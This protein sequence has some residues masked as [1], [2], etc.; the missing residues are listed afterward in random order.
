MPLTVFIADD[1]GIIRDGIS[2]LLNNESDIEVIGVAEH[3]RLAVE[4]ILKLKPDLVLMD[5]SMPEL[6]GIE[7]T[8][9][10]IAAVPT[11]RILALSTYSDHRY[12]SEML[13][14]GAAGYIL[15]DGVFDELLFAIRSVE[16]GQSYLSPPVAHLVLSDYRK[17][18]TGDIQSQEKEIKPILTKR[19]REVLQLLA[20]GK[21]MKDIA[22]S[23]FISTK[24]VETHRKKISDKLGIKSIIDLTKYA[25]REGITSVFK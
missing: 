20:E 25:I 10:L 7:A 23:L 21:T 13:H 16:R 12:V 8:R 17:G 3:G 15:K 9:Q 4:L 19:E 24:T 1:H 11:L 14:A 6:N 2:A 22:N 18:I 5:V